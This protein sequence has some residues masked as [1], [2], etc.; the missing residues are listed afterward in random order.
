[1][2]ERASR[3]D[4][5]AHAARNSNGADELV[6]ECRDGHRQRLPFDLGVDAEDSVVVAAPRIAVATG[7]DRERVV[8]SRRHSADPEAPVSEHLEGTRHELSIPPLSV[9][10]Q[11]KYCL[12][13]T[14]PS[15]RDATLSRMPSSA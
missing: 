1:M 3:G 8:C 12:L 11:A 6:A 9:P 5:A 13:Y 2:P 10:K 7:A 4:G 14:S 15:P